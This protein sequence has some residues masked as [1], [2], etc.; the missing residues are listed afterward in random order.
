MDCIFCRIVAGQ[1]E[2]SLVWRDE[3]C[4]A[5]MDVQPVNQGHILVVPNV[6]AAYLADLD[7]DTAAHLMRIGHRLDAALRAS[8]LPCEGVNL[9]LADGAAAMQHVFHVHLH[10]FPRFAGDGFGLRFG[11]HY[12]ERPGQAML[13]EAAEAVRKG[14]AAPAWLA[15]NDLAWTDT[16]VSSPA[17]CAEETGRYALLIR[18]HARIP[19][20]TL[21][22]FGCGAGAND[23]TFKR[24]F[25][26]TGVDVSPG[27]LDIARVTNPEV[28]YI[29]GDVREINLEERFDA[30]VM[31]DGAADYMASPDELRAAIENACRHLRPGGVLLIVANVRDDIRDNNFVYTGSRDGVEVTIFE[32]DHVSAGGAQYEATLVYLIRRGDSLDIRTDRHTLG[33]FPLETWRS[34]FTGAGLDVEHVL[35]SEGYEKHIMQDG[36]YPRH[37][38]IGTRPM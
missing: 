1:A 13:E 23:F 14:L 5:F 30:V 6:H 37:I 9:F 33:L 15:Y 26:V 7:E 36:E 27:M 35:T 2:A 19:C 31:P 21:L 18:E 38:L 16:V 3:V 8:G 29:L 17:E 24:H 11:P 4:S 22:H 34:L 20:A 28:R 25:Q 32:N 12:Q 10:V